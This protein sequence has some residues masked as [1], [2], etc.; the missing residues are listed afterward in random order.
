[1][2][3]ALVIQHAKHM[4]RIV[5]S[6]ACLFVRQLS[7]L[8][9]KRNDPTCFAHARYYVVVC[10]LS[11]C[12]VFFPHYLINGTIFEKKRRYWT[13]NVCFVFLYNFSV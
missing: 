8:P 9:H 1:V 13:K 6:V 2:R 3:L 4:R 11:S 10:G 7:T 5:S 12:T